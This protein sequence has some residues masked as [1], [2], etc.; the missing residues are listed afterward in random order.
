MHWCDT[1]TSS[2][3]VPKHESVSTETNEDAIVLVMRLITSL[4]NAENKLKLTIK[5]LLCMRCQKTKVAA[6]NVGSLQCGLI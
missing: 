3:E 6:R 4:R 2:F 5:S 1:Q